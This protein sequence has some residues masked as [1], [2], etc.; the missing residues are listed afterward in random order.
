VASIAEI[1][2]AADA[3]VESV[4]R[5]I[6]REPV[7]EPVRE[8]VI[9]AMD[10]HG[11][12][13][14]AVSLATTNDSVREDLLKALEQTAAQLGADLPENVGGLVYEAVRLEVRPVVDGLGEA[15]QLFVTLLTRL[16]EELTSERK[17]RLEDVSLLVDL[18]VTS[19]R[20]VDARLGRVEKLLERLSDPPQTRAFP[21]DAMHR[22][23]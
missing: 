5:V 10:F 17:E 9:E 12:P 16:R 6:T 22:R 20:N 15:R 18:I 21:F 14:Q 19:W 2:R 3:S 8:R 13:R 1:A 11:F 7:S 23:R 4:L